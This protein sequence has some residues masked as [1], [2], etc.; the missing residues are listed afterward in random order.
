MRSS[1]EDTL[2]PAPPSGNDVAE[3]YDDAVIRV[4]VTV[5]DLAATRFGLSPLLETATALRALRSPGRHGVHLPWVRWARERLRSEPLA[6][7]LTTELLVAH[8]QF[9]EFLLPAPDS[10]LETLDQELHRLV[11]TPVA[12]VR[13]SM[14]RRR[15]TRPG[16]GVAAMIRAPRRTLR[17]LAAELRAAHDV[18]IAPFW[19]R[20]Q[21]LLDADVVHRSRTLA[22]RGAAGLLAELDPRVRWHGDHFVVDD[23]QGPRTARV[24]AGGLILQPSV[25]LWPEIWVKPSSV[26]Q[27]TVRYPARGVGLLWTPDAAPTPP[28]AALEALLGVPRARLLRLLAAPCTTGDL[29]ARLNVT[30]SAISQHLRVLRAA[31][32]V[33]TA[34]VGRSRIHVL[35]A[36][37][38]ALAA[39]PSGAGPSSSSAA[40]GARA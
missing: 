1:T 4:D 22:D 9:S 17:A 15:R 37:G 10:R 2:G 27:T 24:A 3:G 26:T 25:F 30:P 28:S 36:T 21:A 39:S 13:S 35:A 14:G 11:T 38:R 40:A 7:P 23:G 12:H 31:G 29:A 6:L 32:L 19:P 8:E 18:L 5:E 33:S 34:T 20:L 16:P